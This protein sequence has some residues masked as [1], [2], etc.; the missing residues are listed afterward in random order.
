MRLLDR[1][2][3]RQFWPPLL[4]AFSA[5]TSIML[6]NQVARRFG[7]LVGKG[8]AFVTAT[9]AEIY[10]AQGTYAESIKAYQEIL[11][12]HPEEKERFEKRIKKQGKI[13]Q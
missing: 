9:M 4:F 2:L 5:M 12:H 1:Y 7:A 11:K 8:Q 3:L 6:I 10:A 13:N